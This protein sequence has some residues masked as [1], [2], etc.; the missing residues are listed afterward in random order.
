[1]AAKLDFKALMLA[2]GE[3]FLLIGA[4]A[5]GALLL[6][7]GVISAFGKIDPV[8]DKKKL[9]DDAA[10]V[11]RQ[12]N[13][14]TT[15]PTT[16]APPLPEFTPI[17][18]DS[19]ASVTTPF[20]Q[21]VWP[22]RFK[23]IP[24]ALPPT[25]S[26]IDLF[27][28]SVRKQAR[29][30]FQKDED[31][32]ITDFIA[33]WITKQLDPKVD[34]KG[35]LK[36]IKDGINAAQGRK[37][38]P[39]TG[40]GRPNPGTPG[41]GLPGG[42]G[43]G[44]PGGPGGG[45]PGGPGGGFPGGPGGG[46]PGGPG[47][48]GMPGQPGGDDGYGGGPGPGGYAPGALASKKTAED[49]VEWKKWS[50]VLESGKPA[51]PAYGVFPVRMGVIQLSYPL[52]EQLKEIQ[53]ALRLPTLRQ[54]ILES[55]PE[56]L[57]ATDP[58]TGKIVPYV[59][60][61]TGVGSGPAA[62]GVPGVPGGPGGPPVGPGRAGAGLGGPG[63]IGAGG[64]GSGEGTGAPLT[65]DTL[66]SPVFGGFI[67]Q[68]RKIFAD[69]VPGDWEEFDHAD[70]YHNEFTLYDAP[71]K[72]DTGYLPYFLRLDQGMAAPMP[73][74]APNWTSAPQLIANETEP[75][76]KHYPE[77]VRMPSIVADFEALQ[78]IL[79][80][81]KKKEA[82]DRYKRNP[83]NPYSTGA[84][85]TG[86][87]GLGMPGQY[88]EDGGPGIG[89]GSGSP[90][91]PVGGATGTQPGTGTDPNKSP[92]AVK[93]MLIRFLDTDLLPGV[94][95]QYRVAV[96]VRN[97]NFGKPKEVADENQ[98]K[99][100]FITSPYF[101][102]KQTL[103]VPAESYMYAGSTKE[104]EK[105]VLDMIDDVKK[106]NPDKDRNGVA[107]DRL[108]KLFEFQETRDGKRA[109][110]QMQRWVYS[111]TFGGE[112]ERIGAWVQADI[113]VAPGEYIGRRT[114]VEI[115]LWKAALGKYQLTPPTKDLVT[116]WP[117]GVT[118]PPGRPVD[119]RTRHVLM[120]YEG[121][122]T[123]ASIDGRSVSDDAATELLI[124]RDDG[125]L[126][127]RKELADAV[128]P[129]RVVR[130]K[131][132]KE[133][134]AEVRKQFDGTGGTAP[135]GFEPGRGGSPGSPSGPPGGSGR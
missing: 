67:V 85:R 13:D 16:A 23:V 106:A 60:L 43:G 111:T 40:G 102:C 115:P 34:H 84:S 99:V 2:R 114:L 1:M 121:G 110:V 55:S 9:D 51:V 82:L 30:N 71:V 118:S 104:Y 123:A 87:S 75:K 128:V 38:K 89:Y 88:D 21:T 44:F 133:W 108:R 125:K 15:P 53:R 62:P 79:K 11:K 77:F 130:D 64:P 26:Q 70:R 74:I 72:P 95:Y 117:K 24:E 36:D 27:L 20:D 19:F 50:E 31:G 135:G 17:T 14:P 91:G 28:V 65:A 68:R 58:E 116:S 107:P 32:N 18:K 63:A 83:N 35:Q 54:A 37:K 39:G 25:D 45:L 105:R 3:R 12:M 120:D 90:R 29:D 10:R 52:E 129:E 97:P 66:T 103:K 98:A 76:E 8:A 48:P 126:E 127:V 42:P 73:Q 96:K 49:V 86:G 80:P 109:V 47:A 46:L 78:K 81:V 112:E 61:A 122:K 6:I 134:I 41:G 131:N 93:H 4:V 22:D 92:L 69:G 100:E 5:I 113:P 7:W 101:Q 132:W 33:Q 56:K 119:F 124:L 59:S 94:S 57:L